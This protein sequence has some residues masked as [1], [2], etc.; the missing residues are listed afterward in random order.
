M[1]KVILLTTMFVL[2][3]ISLFPMLSMFYTAVIPSGNLTKIIKERYIND[4]EIKYKSYLRRKL[5]GQFTLVN[6]SPQSTKSIL[7]NGTIVLLT[8][9]LDMRVAKQLE[10]WAKG[11]EN[12]SLEIFDAFGKS[13]KKEFSGSKDWKKYTLTNFGEINLKY[14]SKIV[15]HFSDKHYL[16]DVKLIYK[17]PTL[18]NFVNVLKEDMFTRYILNSL[19]VSTVVVIGNIIFSTMV[20]YAFA[21][22]NF[23]GK[24]LLFSIILMTMM[25]PP[26]ITIIPIFILMKNI[27][28]ID[29]YFALTVPMLVTPFSVFL[30]KQYIEQ[31]PIELEQAAYV[32]GANTFQILFKIVFP[33]S[34]PAIAVM[35]INTFISSWNALF[36]PLV[37]T[38]SREMRTV[39]VGLALYQK[40]NQIDWPRLMAASSIIGIPVI[41]IFLA[42]QKHII[43]GITKGAL[44]G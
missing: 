17:F 19:I 11:K 31:L 34:K 27:G 4:F 23:F 40:L 15:F 22:R 7:A 36:Y 43:S 32:D 26:Q 10:F 20:A 41:I 16:D 5:N 33:L 18:L 8:N 12:F 14:V 35:A 25:I 30:L 37:M 6:D 42:F 21:R 39:Q 24:N 13:I 2:L 38:N 29:T 28:W 9:K 3:F 44:K 1:K